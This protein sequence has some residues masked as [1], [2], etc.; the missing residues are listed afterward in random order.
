MFANT[1]ISSLVYLCEYRYNY[2]KFSKQCGLSPVASRITADKVGG[3]T[4]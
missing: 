1:R 3:M 4:F 2:L